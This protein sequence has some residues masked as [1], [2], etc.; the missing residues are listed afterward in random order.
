MFHPFSSSSGLVQ[1]NFSCADW[2]RSITDHILL[3]KFTDCSD[4]V[5]VVLR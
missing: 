2:Y 4:T 3:L 5:L 1:Y